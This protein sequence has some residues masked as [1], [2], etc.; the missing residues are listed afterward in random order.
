MTESH[1][2]QPSPPEK[3]A[4]NRKAGKR[5]GKARKTPASDQKKNLD[6]DE[7][8]RWAVG[9]SGNSRGRPPITPEMK[10]VKALCEV[11]RAANVAGLVN[12]R[13]SAEDVWARI[14]AIKILLMYSDGKPVTAIASNGPLVNVN[15][16]NGAPI[17]DA[18][19]AARIYAEF[20]SNPALDMSNL[21]FASPALPAA[22]AAAQPAA[23]D[24]RVA[25]IANTKAAEW[26]RL[27]NE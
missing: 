26:E 22:A 12:I 20:C 3:H 21:A 27:A 23:V 10:Q 24:A 6:R 14:E 11:E 4:A 15:I 17:T 7:K 8:G 25:P 9:V 18:A 1:T 19:E 16:A 13:D 2:E 5:G